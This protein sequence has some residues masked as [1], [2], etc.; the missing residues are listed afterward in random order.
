MNMP[1]HNFT[2]HCFYISKK[3]SLWNEYKKVDITERSASSRNMS[4]VRD[5]H[6]YWIKKSL[7]DLV[8]IGIKYRNFHVTP[9]LFSQPNYERQLHIEFVNVVLR[10]RISIMRSA[11]G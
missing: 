4:I 11:P 10:W 7:P 8:L 2:L 1:L 9:V 3:V 5:P 6:I